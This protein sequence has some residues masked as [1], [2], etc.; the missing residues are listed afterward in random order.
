MLSY[1]E[2]RQ[3]VIEVVGTRCRA[4]GIP[5]GE[6]VELNQALGRILAEQVV[7]DRDYPPFDRATRDGF[8]VRAEDLR[9]VPATLEIVG[10]VRAGQAFAGKME[11]GQCVQIM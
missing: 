5:P 6:E 9:T 7:A 2:A 4:R 3:K 11:N 1:S 10:E 8:A